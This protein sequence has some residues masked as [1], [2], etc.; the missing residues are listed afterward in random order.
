MKTSHNV[1]QRI[2]KPKRN[3]TGEAAIGAVAGRR[4]EEIDGGI[5]ELQR[6]GEGEA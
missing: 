5:R 3:L 1:T 2:K 4:G 6:I